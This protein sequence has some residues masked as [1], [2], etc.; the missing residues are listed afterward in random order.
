MEIILACSKCGKELTGFIWP[1]E[2]RAVDVLRK[3]Q[4][5]VDPCRC[6]SLLPS[7]INEVDGSFTCAITGKNIIWE[8]R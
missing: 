2:K 4:I 6:E 3:F 7:C 1:P 5:V 8:K